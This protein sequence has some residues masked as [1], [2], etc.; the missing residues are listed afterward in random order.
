MDT[1]LEISSPT[2]MQQIMDNVIREL[3]LKKEQ[4][5][6]DKFTEK[7]FANLLENLSK[8]RFERIRVERCC[9]REEWYADNG[10]DEG[11]L[12]V[13]FLNQ[14]QLTNGIDNALQM[15]AEIKYY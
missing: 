10:T 11:V 7:G 2:Y 12:I 3:C 5:I 6:K 15:T 4:V 14:T 9:D 1:I 8:N 13:T